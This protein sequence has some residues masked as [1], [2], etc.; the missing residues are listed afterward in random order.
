M[1]PE[2]WNLSIEL[3]PLEQSIV[4]RIK[5]A[6]LFTFL[7]QYRHQLFDEEFQAELGKLYADSPKEHPPVPPGQLLLVTILQAYTATSDAEV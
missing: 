1:R 2:N 4:K 5:R 3:S 6:K 7:Q